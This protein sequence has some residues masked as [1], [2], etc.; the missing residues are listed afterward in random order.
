MV[1][2]EIAQKLRLALE[3]GDKE[4][5][6]AVT[7]AALEQGVSPLEMVQ[8]VIVPSLTHVGELLENLDIFLPELMAAG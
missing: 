4:V 8:E 7:R 5:A 3:E 2:N 6:T 1:P